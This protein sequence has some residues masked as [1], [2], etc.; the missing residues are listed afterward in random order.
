MIWEK[1]L[2]TKTWILS[3]YMYSFY[4]L[5]IWD[6]RDKIPCSKLV[7]LRQQILLFHV[8]DDLDVCICCHAFIALTN[9]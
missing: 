4:L 1:K 5:I 2:L 6:E 7:R 8:Y 3:T 9:T